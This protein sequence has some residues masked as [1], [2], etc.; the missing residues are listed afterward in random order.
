MVNRS[1]VALASAR[2]QLREEITI[3]QAFLDCFE[4]PS[5]GGQRRAQVD[6][7][8]MN[9]T[10]KNFPLPDQFSPDHVDL[11]VPIPDFPAGAPSG[12]YLVNGNSDV[13]IDQIR[14]MCN[15]SH[16]VPKV[17]GYTWICH[18]YVRNQWRRNS[19]APCEGDNLGKYL[20]AFFFK[21][22]DRDG[23]RPCLCSTES[24]ATLAHVHRPQSTRAL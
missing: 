4:P 3:V 5:G 14:R 6:H 11:L 7:T 9:L 21:L 22:E 24:P 2:A 15:G 19:K 13:A 8:C 16:H 18:A 12:M 10:V 17:P 20:A 23:K 1:P